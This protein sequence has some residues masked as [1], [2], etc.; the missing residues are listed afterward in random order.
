MKIL[1]MEAPLSVN[2]IVSI[3]L[4]ARI[5]MALYAVDDDDLIHAADAQN[6]KIYWCLDCFGPVKR[7]KG[8]WKIP[9]FYHLKVSPSCKLYSKSEDHLIAQLEL[10]RFF[11]K[12]VLHVEKPFIQINRVADACLEKEKIIFEIQCSL[13]TE[14]EVKERIHDYK[15]IGYDVVWLLDDKRFNKRMARPAEEFLRTTSSYFLSIRRNIAYDQF[16]VFSKGKRVKKGRPLPINLS[17][18]LRAPK[19]EFDNTTYP[20]QITQL[21]LC[22]HFYG[23]RLSLALHFPLS[24]KREKA[25]ED[26]YLCKKRHPIREFFQKY[27]VEPYFQWLARRLKVR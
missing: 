16:E 20:R 10:Q 26:R 5:F 2:M 19:R 9:H 8:K 15:S 12:G 27:I 24:M 3:Q 25:L 22:R 23:D 6:N 14:Y 18:P 21:K 11:P 1:W 7:R 13:I 17:R 4:F